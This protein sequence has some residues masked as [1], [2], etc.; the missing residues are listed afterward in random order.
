MSGGGNKKRPTKSQGWEEAGAE[1]YQES[2]PTDG[3]LDV[4]QRDPKHLA[5]LLPS[6]QTRG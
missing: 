1:F 6:K 5:T 3:E 2:Y 4:L